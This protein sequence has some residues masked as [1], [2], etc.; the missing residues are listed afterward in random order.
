M[1]VIDYLQDRGFSAKVVGTR[2]FVSPSRR[3]TQ[4][5]RRYIKL[6]RLELMAEVAASDGEARRSHWTVSVTGYG[7]FTMIVEPMTHTEAL[8]EARMLWPEANVE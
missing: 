7:P 2:L 6:H 3:L 8:A 5:E 4:E 1:G